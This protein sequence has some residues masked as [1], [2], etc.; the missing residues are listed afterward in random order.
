MRQGIRQ[1][2]SPFVPCS[3]SL[4]TFS[5]FTVTH[6]DAHTKARVGLLETAHGIVETPEF[7]PVGTQ[8][9]VKALS[10]E[11]LEYC[12]V[13]I[14]LGNTYHLYLRPGT[15]VIKNAGGLHRFMS[16][17][18]PILT[19]SGGFQIFSLATLRK[20][21]EEGVEFK[22]HIDGSKHFLTPENVVRLQ[23]ELGSDIM[24]PLD[25][26]LHYPCPKD[27]VE[28]SLRLTTDWAKRSKKE[29]ESRIT[30]DGRR[31]LFGIVQGSTYPDLRKQAVEQLIDIGFDGYAVGGLSVGEPNELI[32]EMIE[33]SVR[34]LPEDKPRYAM[35][36]G[37][38]HDFFNAIEKGIDMFECVVPTRNARNG[39][40]YTN[41]G[42]LI[43]RNSEYSK[44]LR[45]LS[46][47]CD[48]IVC[49]RYS[50]S[51]IRHLF[52]TEEILGLRLTSL[53][54]V[55]FYV[56]LLKRIRE[57]IKLGGFLKLKE[58][59]KNRVF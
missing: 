38:P 53:H 59:F 37:M 58:E 15:E 12:G 44:D 19:D 21:K 45:P 35:G 27:E 25:E 50:R 4:H 9:T 10:N 47:S 46:E 30:G 56:N 26:C 31:L 42:R 36:I 41:E 23:C 20:V 39:A 11:E 13:Q 24:M 16:W 17:D 3:L 6:R 14:I 1:K 52:N 18:K 57:A 33:N 2:P 55:Y 29:F 51:Y 7:M 34:Y 54:N 43:I 32:C 5:M 22:S 48:C 28:R 40:A 49:K 8:A